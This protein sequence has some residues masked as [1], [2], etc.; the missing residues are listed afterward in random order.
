MDKSALIILRNQFDGLIHTMPDEG[1]E[2]WFAR[3]MMEPLGYI[4]WENFKTAQPKAGKI[5]K[6]F[7]IA[8]SI[9]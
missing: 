3:E 8:W 5:N 4:R 1:I 2:V 7:M 9:D 6:E